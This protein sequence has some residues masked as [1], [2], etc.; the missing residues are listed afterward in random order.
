MVTY[1]LV[2]GAWHGGWCWRRVAPLL[3]GAGREVFALTL[4]GLGERAH[5]AHPGVDLELHIRDV[6]GVLEYED[7]EQVV[8]VGHSYAGM[9]IRGVAERAAGR[10]AHLVYLDAFIPRDGQ[11]LSDLLP[12]EGWERMRAAAQAEGDGWRIPPFPVQA[13]GVTADADVQWVGPKLV[14]Q[15]AGTFRQ[16]VRL[17][18]GAAET[19]PRTFI[20]CSK[21]AMGTFDQFLE[22]VRSGGWRYRELATGHDAMV[23]EPEQLA[24]LLLEVAD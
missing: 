10:L 8:L 6:L 14:A 2:H 7:L 18:G 19:L 17:A 23:T 13:F 15:P 16:P 1:L 21:P 5:L 11:S 9:V 12:P 4:T 24:D 20:Y 22:T 3:R